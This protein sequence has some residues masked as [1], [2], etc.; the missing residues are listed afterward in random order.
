MRLLIIDDEAAPTNFPVVVTTAD[1]ID[2]VV[3]FVDPINMPAGI[4]AGDLLLCIYTSNGSSGTSTFTAGWTAVYQDQ[5]DST[6]NQLSVIWKI[7]A[8]GDA[9]TIT[10]TAARP[11]SATVYRIT[12]GSNV[13]ANHAQSN[14]ATAPDPTALSPG[15]LAAYLVFAVTAG[16]QASV[17]NSAPSGYGNI[18][19]N[20]CTFGGPNLGMARANVAASTVDPGASANSATV[21]VMATVAVA[22]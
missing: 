20:T 19:N 11:L 18:I 3:N 9:L 8:G 12:G 22:P 17:M 21:F 1:T 13:Y 10:K 14:S 2:N 6:A 4:A 5:Y 16:N 7:A 15:A